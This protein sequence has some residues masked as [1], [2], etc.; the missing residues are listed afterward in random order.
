MKIDRRCMLKSAGLVPLLGAETDLSLAAAQTPAS[1]PDYTIRI[2]TGFAELSP[3]HL[4][5]TTLY[6]SQFPGPLI[7]FGGGQRVVVD[8]RND[9]D[10]PEIG[11]WHWPDDSERR[12]WLSR[13]RNAF[14]PRAKRASHFVRAEAGRLSLLPYPRGCAR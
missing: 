13:T 11:H 6:N 7:R 3:D 1:K 2:A 9:T 4:V 12:R 10:T 5:S 8:I 14:C